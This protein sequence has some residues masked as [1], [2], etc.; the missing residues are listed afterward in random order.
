LWDPSSGAA[1]RTF[2][3]TGEVDAVA[4]SHAGRYLAAATTDGAVRLWDREQNW[5]LRELAG[6]SAWVDSV[7]FSPNDELLI[8][9]SDDWT[10]RVWSVETGRTVLLLKTPGVCVGAAFSPDGKRIATGWGKGVRIA[11]LDLST[12][13]AEPTRLLATAQEEAG[14]ELDGVSL[15]PLD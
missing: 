11:P 15:V 14:M 6:H 2:E 10:A 9:G 5:T 4:F 8:T 12:R 3:Q 1:L 7:A 13:D